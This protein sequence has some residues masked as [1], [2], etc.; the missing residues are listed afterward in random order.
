MSK[1]KYTPETVLSYLGRK[2]YKLDKLV[3]KKQRKRTAPEKQAELYF[4]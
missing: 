3:H 4:K 1:Q 2:F